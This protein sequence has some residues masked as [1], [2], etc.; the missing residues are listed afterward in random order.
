MLSMYSLIEILSFLW[1]IILLLLL[2]GLVSMLF[3]D[4]P[5]AGFAHYNIWLAVAYSI[6][7]AYTTFLCFTVK[8][9][10]FI[11][12][13]LVASVCYGTLEFRIKRTQKTKRIRSGGLKEEGKPPENTSMV[14]S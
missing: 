7:F 13:L 6:C 3:V 12:S 1:T 8:T 4:N 5:E 2:S 9:Y 11:A 14:E 10:I